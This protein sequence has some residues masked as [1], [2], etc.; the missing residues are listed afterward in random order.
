MT[1]QQSA[2]VK[3]L[4]FFLAALSCM[5]LAGCRASPTPSPDAPVE[6]VSTRTI[7]TDKG[8]FEVPGIAYIDGRDPNASPPLTIRNINIWSSPDRL[9][10][11]DPTKVPCRLKHGTSVEL[12][13][14]K[15]NASESRYYFR[16]RS[17]SCE[18]WLPEPFLSREYEEPVG[19]WF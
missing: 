19:D 7:T 9:S 14:Y 17:G 3:Q 18:G 13:D 6:D 11:A 15:L 8:T 5:V 16:I 10:S 12:T 1:E 4:L 2:K